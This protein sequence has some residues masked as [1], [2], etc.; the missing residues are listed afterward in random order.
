MDNSVVVRTYVLD[1]PVDK[2]KGQEEMAADI[3]TYISSGFTILSH[4]VVLSESPYYHQLIHTLIFSK[5][6]E[7]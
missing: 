6:G 4:A 7:T 1:L 5:T 3:A 2:I